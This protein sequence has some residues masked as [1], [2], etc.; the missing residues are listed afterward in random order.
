M[1]ITEQTSLH[2]Q[3]LSG[4]KVIAKFSTT[5]WRLK[6]AAWIITD[7]VAT[8]MKLSVQP[9][10]L[11]NN[12]QLRYWRTEVADDCGLHIRS[13]AAQPGQT[14]T[15]P[16]ISTATISLQCIT[17]NTPV[18]TRITKNNKVNLQTVVCKRG[19]HQTP[20]HTQR[21][22]TKFNTETNTANMYA[23]AVSIHTFVHMTLTF[24][25][26]PWKPTASHKVGL[27][28]QTMDTHTT[29]KHNAFALLLLVRHK[30]AIIPQGRRQYIQWVANYSI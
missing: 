4:G 16:C 26:W 27:K 14:N 21:P 30:N 19:P 9:G 7:I 12:C 11:S 3:I 10:A 24:D 2:N 23:Y 17:V 8:V 29:R 25:L 5:S 18:T 6:T 13:T 28:G 1:N 15:V 22:L 20:N